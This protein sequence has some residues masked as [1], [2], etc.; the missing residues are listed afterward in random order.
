MQMKIN[1]TVLS[2]ETTSTQELTVSIPEKKN[3]NIWG[4]VHQT[5]VFEFYPYQG[6]QGLLC[7]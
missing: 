3:S 2:L 5:Q 7:L 1:M 4:R 6:L